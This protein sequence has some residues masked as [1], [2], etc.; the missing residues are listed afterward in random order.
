MELGGAATSTGYPSA[1][2]NGSNGSE[3]QTGGGGSGGHLSSSNSGARWYILFRRK[4]R[5]IFS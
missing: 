3:R 4:W 2:I 5:R 1:G